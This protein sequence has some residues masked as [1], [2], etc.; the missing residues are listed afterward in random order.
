MQNNDKNIKET[1]EKNDTKLKKNPCELL[2]SV[3][4][5]A[6]A[7]PELRNEVKGAISQVTELIAKASRGQS[8]GVGLDVSM[9]AH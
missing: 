1:V 6:A 5:H 4:A 3:I 7:I 8:S 2:G 9:A